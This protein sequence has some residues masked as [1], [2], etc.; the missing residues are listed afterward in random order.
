MAGTLSASVEATSTAP[1]LSEARLARLGRFCKGGM[2][3][4]TVTSKD[5][6]TIAFDR[7][8]NGPVLILVDGATMHRAMGSGMA[9]RLARDFTVIQY[10]RRGRGDST[11]TE[12]YAVQREI[13]DIEA[14]IDEV[15][16]SAFLVGFSSGAALAMEAAI[17]RP[18]KVSGLAMYEAPYNSD[19][20]ARRRWRQYRRQL[21]E[22]VAEGRRGDA[23]GLFMSYVGMPPDQIEGM[24]QHPMW[25]ML[26][27][28]APTLPYDAAVLG[29]DASVPVE[30]AGRVA[31]P[32]LVMDG[33]AGMPFMHTTAM[34]LA[35]A[36]PGAQHRTLEGQTHEVS[37]EALAPVLVEFFRSD[38]SRR[39]AA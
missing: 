29:E 34:A 39:I 25:P 27:S 14:L 11:D 8:G 23:V 20:I 19:E 4:N 1:S 36:I 31:V 13:E 28:V 12:P 17:E 33:G 24:H 3:V 6:T 37:P 16:G 26:E 32:T 21:D 10:D 35:K 15:G 22:A 30:R 2:G 38:R 5:G 7:S 9:Q 18:G